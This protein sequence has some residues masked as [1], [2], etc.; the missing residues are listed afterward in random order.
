M[1]VIARN[2]AAIS[3]FGPIRRRGV[4]NG[5][6]FESDFPFLGISAVPDLYYHLGQS[7]IFLICH[8]SRLGHGLGKISDAF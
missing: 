5:Q 6:G 1:A 7:T 8:S 3:H 2:L 4:F